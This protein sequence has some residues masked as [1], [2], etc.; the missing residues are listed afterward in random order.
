[1]KEIFINVRVAIYTYNLKIF[2]NYIFH[3]NEGFI[4]MNLHT[5]SFGCAGGNE[6]ATVSTCVTFKLFS[7]VLLFAAPMEPKKRPC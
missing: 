6:L 4:S 7:A 1:M 3:K 5:K 2:E